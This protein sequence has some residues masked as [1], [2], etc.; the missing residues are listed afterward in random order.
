MCTRWTRRWHALCSWRQALRRYALTAQYDRYH[1]PPTYRTSAHPAHGGGEPLALR[2][3]WPLRPVRE[4]RALCGVPRADVARDGGLHGV[5]ND[6]DR[7]AR[8]REGAR[9][10]IGRL[11]SRPDPPSGSDPSR[12]AD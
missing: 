8:G 4:R 2:D 1:E 10:P 6:E 3:A 7:G 12:P 9:L 5:R 11:T